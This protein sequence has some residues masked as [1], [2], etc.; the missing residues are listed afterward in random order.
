MRRPVE[1]GERLQGWYRLF[2]YLVHQVGLDF[3]LCFAVLQQIISS[4]V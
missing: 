3:L 1:R 4:S 2:A